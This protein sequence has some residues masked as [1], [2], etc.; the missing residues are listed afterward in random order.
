MSWLQQE[1]VMREPDSR[2]IRSITDAEFALFQRL[3]RRET[4]ISLSQAKKGL[5]TS[6][7]VRRLKERGFTS[8]R[9][10]YNHILAGDETE[11]LRFIDA[12][13]TNETRFFRE[14]QQFTFLEQQLFPI[15]K[16]RAS[17]GTMPRRVRVWS[18]ACSTGEEPYS[19][20]MLLGDH[21]PLHCR[22]E[23]IVLAS[24][25]STRA[26][27]R[28]Q[29]G[30]WPLEKA[31]DI[32]L[33]HLKAWMLKGTRTQAGWMKAGSEIRSLVRFERINLVDP[34]YGDVGQFEAIF[35]RNVLIYFDTPTRNRVVRQLAEHLTPGGH[36]FVGHAES[37][38]GVSER[39]RCVMPTVYQDVRV[40]D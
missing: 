18:A 17:A 12:I 25:I 31:K 8:F 4:G 29:Q 32:P 14:P 9:Q 22:W 16:A 20:A 24:D 30:M 21:F 1:P 36:L 2:A 3:I 10:Y 39:L 26:L 19:I 33:R 28:A 5:L 34:S 35:C 6:R 15:W 11:H 27:E 37:L 7:L 23:A 40:R 38:A 13:C